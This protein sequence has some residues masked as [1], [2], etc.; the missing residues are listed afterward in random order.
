VTT[1]HRDIQIVPSPAREKISHNPAANSA[2]AEREGRRDA[3]IVGVIAIALA[4]Y[5]IA[6]NR[7]CLL[8]FFWCDDLWLLH[9]A[10]KIDVGSIPGVAQIFVPG[11]LG[12]G[13]YRPLTT[14][15]Y[16]SLLRQLFDVDSSGL[17]CRADAAARRLPGWEPR[18]DWLRRAAGWA[19]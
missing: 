2:R 7:D 16:Y 17:S 10:A 19:P 12:F 13:L 8:L 15:G 14:V 3:I 9:D 5:C 6:R 18:F 11:D 1:E 4:A